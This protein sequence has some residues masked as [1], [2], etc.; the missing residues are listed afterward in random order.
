M[1]HL[2]TVNRF[3][4]L[5]CRRLV[6]RSMPAKQT[7]R[8]Q[9]MSRFTL[10]CPVCPKYQQNRVRT[11][12]LLLERGGGRERQRQRETERDRHR[13]VGEKKVYSGNYG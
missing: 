13:E 4:S 10:R 11:E 6:I 1:R 8:L 3:R 7:D 2:S 5:T 12:Y 9:E